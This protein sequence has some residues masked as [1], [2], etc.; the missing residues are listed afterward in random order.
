MNT[1]EELNEKEIQLLLCKDL[2]SDYW[3]T[4]NM[5]RLSDLFAVHY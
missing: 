5:L 1:Y 3:K 4:E 2:I